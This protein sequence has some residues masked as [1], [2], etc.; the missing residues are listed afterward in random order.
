MDDYVTF[1]GELRARFDKELDIKDKLE[2]KATSTITVA[3]IMAAIFM[4]FG[5]AVLDNVDTSS[6][7]FMPAMGIWL[8]ELVATLVT[9]VFGIVGYRAGT[10]D[11][12]LVRSEF[13]DDNENYDKDRIMSYKKIDDA[14]YYEMSQKYL[15]CIMENG[16]M[17][18]KKVTRIDLAQYA[19]I[20][21]I[22]LIPIFAALVI[23]SQI[24]GSPTPAVGAGT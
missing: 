7:Y 2:G 11:F 1:L 9:V 22:V 13:V 5:S 3:G 12:P 8:A 18:D 19:L 6:Q 10:Y 16:K 21:A 24:P 20:A 14:K 4:A 15:K 17:N 23:L